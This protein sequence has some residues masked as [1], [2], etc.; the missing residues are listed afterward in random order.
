MTSNLDL[1]RSTCEGAPADNPGPR[2]TQVVDS[3]IVN[4][5]LAA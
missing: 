1:I 2:M 3:A 5:A 4:R